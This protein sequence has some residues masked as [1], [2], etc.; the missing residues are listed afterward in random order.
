MTSYQ[1]NM[2]FS[3]IEPVYQD[4]IDINSNDMGY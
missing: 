3:E 2:T 1:I 4:D